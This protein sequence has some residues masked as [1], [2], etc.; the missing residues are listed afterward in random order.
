[1]KKSII[2]AGLVVLFAT[3]F[4][5]TQAQSEVPVKIL[6]SLQAGL[7]KVLFVHGNQQS[8]NV[9][10][11]NDQGLYTLDVIEKESF[12]NGFLKRYDISL[13]GSKDFWVEISLQDMSVTATYKMTKSDHNTY[14]PQ[15]ENT[16]FNHSVLASIN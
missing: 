10:F 12:K 4:S 1:M 6:P 13:V 11:Y 8:V 16:T 14:E 9:K 2:V 7:M 15:L 5:N 3:I